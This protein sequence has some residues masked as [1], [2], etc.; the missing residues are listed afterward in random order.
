MGGGGGG[1]GFSPR[2]L[3]SLEKRAREELQKAQ[4]RNV[5]LSFAY[6]DINDINLLRAQAKN[7]NAEI[8]FNDWSVQEPFDS[9]RA[10]YIQQRIS[11]RISQSSV[12]V[13]YLSPDSARSSW[14]T[15]EVEE[16]LRRGKTVIAVHKGEAP[17]AQ[18]P[19]IVTANKITIIPWSSLA[20]TIK[21]LK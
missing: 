14:V 18:V 4:R 12:V 17:P 15:W 7:E 16:G 8:E 20:G 9:E 3:S 21:L 10:P 11:E 19:A 6:E 13:V 2:D 5:F 1:G